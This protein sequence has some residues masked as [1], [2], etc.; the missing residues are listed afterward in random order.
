MSNV[1][2]A[3][4]MWERDGIGDGHTLSRQPGGGG[5]GLISKVCVESGV[6]NIPATSRQPGGG[7]GGGGLSRKGVFSSLLYQPF[8][9]MLK[10]FF[11][12]WFFV[13]I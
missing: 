13:F 1:G 12:C 9:K 11:F 3:G 6:C 7:G 4:T 2:V 10:P 8:Y 5:G